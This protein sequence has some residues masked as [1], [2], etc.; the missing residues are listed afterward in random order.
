MHQPPQSLDLLGIPEFVQNQMIK[1]IGKKM[2]LC[3]ILSE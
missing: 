3:K 2:E 1:L